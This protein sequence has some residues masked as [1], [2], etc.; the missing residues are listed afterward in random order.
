MLS[1]MFVLFVSLLQEE[2]V[3]ALMLLH[4]VIIA[5]CVKYIT[6]QHRSRAPVGTP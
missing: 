5:A 2:L 6:A 3:L 1:V 4:H